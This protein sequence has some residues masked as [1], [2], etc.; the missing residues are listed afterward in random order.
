MLLFRIGC[1]AALLVMASA[2]FSLGASSHTPGYASATTTTYEFTLESSSVQIGVGWQF[3]V[4][5]PTDTFT[6]TSVTGCSF[7]LNSQIVAAAT[8]SI[9][10]T[11]N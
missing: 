4:S 6:I 11:N 1:V 10:S 5:F 9:N 2:A 7:A 3:L 8:C